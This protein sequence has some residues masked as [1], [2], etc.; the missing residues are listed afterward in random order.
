MLGV[1]SGLVTS[2][3]SCS[4]CGLCVSCFLHFY[5]CIIGMC[6]NFHD[7]RHNW[8]LISFFFNR[9][10]HEFPKKIGFPFHNY[11]SPKFPLTYGIYIDSILYPTSTYKLTACPPSVRKLKQLWYDWACYD[12]NFDIAQEWWNGKKLAHAPTIWSVFFGWCGIFV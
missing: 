4:L 9:L 1:S 11:S 12:R 6:Q 3:N 7:V 10:Y 8:T 2:C 5:L